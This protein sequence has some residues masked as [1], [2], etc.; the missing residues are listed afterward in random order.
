MLDVIK[1]LIPLLD[2]V[3]SGAVW[4]VAAYFGLLLIKMLLIAGSVLL[5][6]SWVVKVL[7]SWLGADKIIKNDWNMFQWDDW[8]GRQPVNALFEKKDMKDLLLA[9]ASPTGR[10]TSWDIQQAT[11]KL[12]QK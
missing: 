2:G 8:R 7:L 6:L 12:K 3:R 10:V 9:L 11:E 5:A 4:L 1:E